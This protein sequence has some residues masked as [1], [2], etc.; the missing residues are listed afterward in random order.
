MCVCVCVCCAQALISSRMWA[1][2]AGIVMREDVDDEL[3]VMA[4][5]V[6]SRALCNPA[7]DR[8]SIAGSLVHAGV[9]EQALLL[10]GGEKA[11]ASDN[12]VRRS[13]ECFWGTPEKSVSHIKPYIL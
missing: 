9:V 8:R 11:Y 3:L 10:V 2:Q 1:C 12:D 7:L 13:L 5:V 6:L 4:L